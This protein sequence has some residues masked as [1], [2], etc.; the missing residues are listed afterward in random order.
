V[1]YTIVF[2]IQPIK[3]DTST[4]TSTSGV[5]T[6]ADAVKTSDSKSHVTAAAA[7]AAAFRVSANPL[8]GERYPYISVMWPG[9]I[10][11]LSG[12][13]ATGLYVMENAGQTHPASDVVSG[14]HP[15]GVWQRDVLARFA[16]HEAT[17]ARVLESLQL[18]RGCVACANEDEDKAATKTPMPVSISSTTPTSPTAA[19]AA[20]PIPSNA[21]LAGTCGPGCV[22]VF[23]R[24][25]SAN[26][27]KVNTDAADHVV[28]I[29]EKNVSKEQLLNNGDDAAAF[30]V[31]GDRWHSVVRKP[32]TSLLCDTPRHP[33]RSL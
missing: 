20:M 9:F 17:P 14:L 2:A 24:P 6:S 22:F 8:P 7:A 12:V 3:P 26:S 29:K 23:A 25:P 31:E 19:G 28:T 16:A 13:N 27:A 32:G 11:T 18:F 5:P 4:S 30:V 10:G 21:S 33:C 1:L 15:V